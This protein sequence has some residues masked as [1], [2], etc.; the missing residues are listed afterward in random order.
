[1]LAIAAVILTTSPAVARD[2]L[3]DMLAGKSAVQGRKLKK[4]IEKADTQPL[5]SDAN[6]V[7]S[8]GPQGQRAY[9]ARLRCEDGRQPAFERMG[10][11][12]IGPFGNIIDAYSVQCQDSQPADTTIYMDLYHAGYVETR[13]VPGFTIEAP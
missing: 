2:P 13:P 3:A 12:G 7:R 9:L 10:S 8:T 5:G 6:P 1:M 4:A 11:M